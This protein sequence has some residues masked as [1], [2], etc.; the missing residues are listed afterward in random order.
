MIRLKAPAK[1]NL[2]LKVLRKRPDGYHE[3]ETIFERVNLFDE[4]T[5]KKIRSGIQLRSSGLCLPRGRRNLVYRA[6]E[7]LNR[8]YPSSGG[9]SITLN[10]R[11][12]IAAGLGGGSSDAATTLLALNK[13]WNLKLSKLC[14]LVHAEELGSDVPFFILER[15][16]ALGWGRGEKL[17]ALSYRRKLWHVLVTPTFPVLASDVYRSLRAADLTRSGGN[18][19]ISFKSLR[20]FNTLERVI[21]KKHK[22]IQDMKEGLLEAGAREALVSGS[23]P[24]LFGLADSS[25]HA[26]K[27]ARKIRKAT[28][29]P[30]RIVSTY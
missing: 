19:R 10:K 3:L 14:L 9:V 6:A 24:S 2:Y 23:G 7:L 22:T 18:A 8:H 16:F 29:F 21:L 27:I 28:P 17:R 26:A 5:F 12:P 15:S 20:L 4:L 13:L 30:V 11:I 1:V 25:A